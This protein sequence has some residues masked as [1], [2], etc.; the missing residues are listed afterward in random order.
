MD[1]EYRWRFF[2]H[3]QR[4]PMIAPVWRRHA[5]AVEG[6]ASNRARSKRTW[7]EAVKRVVVVVNLTMGVEAFVIAT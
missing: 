3:V 5:I 7:I 1:K 2:I 6:V 4:R